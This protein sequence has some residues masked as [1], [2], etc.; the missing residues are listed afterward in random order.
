MG[1]YTIDRRGFVPAARVQL[2][3]DIMDMILD[4]SPADHQTFG[5]FPVRISRAD[6]AEDFALASC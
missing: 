4:G 6:E 3:E 2:L 5:Y 1:M